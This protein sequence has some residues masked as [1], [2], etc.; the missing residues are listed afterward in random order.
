MRVTIFYLQGVR[1]TYIKKKLKNFINNILAVVA[2][3]QKIKN[4]GEDK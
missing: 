1:T 2:I 4:S 3:E